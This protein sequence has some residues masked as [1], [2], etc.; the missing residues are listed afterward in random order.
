MVTCL[1]DKYIKRIMVDASLLSIWVICTILQVTIRAFH[2]ILDK[3][4]FGLTGSTS[5]KMHPLGLIEHKYLKYAPCKRLLSPFFVTLLAWHLII[6]GYHSSNFIIM[7]SQNF[8]WYSSFWLCVRD[9]PQAL[10]IPPQEKQFMVVDFVRTMEFDV[11]M[12]SMA[13]LFCL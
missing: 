13:F 8:W 1:N 4:P 5:Y 6:S 7:R 11:T 12:A 9:F 2:T 10:I 3:L